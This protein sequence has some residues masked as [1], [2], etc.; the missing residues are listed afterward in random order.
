M[1]AWKLEKENTFLRD[2]LQN[3]NIEILIESI[4]DLSKK[5]ITQSFPYNQNGKGNWNNDRDTKS[6]EETNV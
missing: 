1:V 2:D 3:K 5:I 6:S 4:T